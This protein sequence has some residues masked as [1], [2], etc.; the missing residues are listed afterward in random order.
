[1]YFDQ[2]DVSANRDG[3]ARITQFLK[4]QLSRNGYAPRAI[5]QIVVLA[6]ELFT[7]CCWRLKEGESVCL[8][9]TV[10]P[11]TRSVT[12]RVRVPLGGRNPLDAAE[13]MAA[14]QT[15]R[16]IRASADKTSFTPGGAEDILTVEKRPE[17][18]VS[19]GEAQES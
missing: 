6:G 5:A 16:F 8:E 10:N 4:R 14:E 7:L 2:C 3:E 13:G 15:A 17:D 1:M 12:L 19:E 11:Q 9:C 18:T